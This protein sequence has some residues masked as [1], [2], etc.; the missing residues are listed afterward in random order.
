MHIY[1]ALIGA[2][3]TLAYVFSRFGLVRQG[4][5]DATDTVESMAGAWRRWKVRAKPART[6][7]EAETDPR[8]AAAAIMVSIAESAGPLSATGEAALAREF[9]NVLGASDGSELVIYGRW[10]TRDL[11][12]PNAVS[13]QVAG[14]L[15]RQLWHAQKE[16]LLD[17]AARISHGDAVQMRAIDHLKGKLGL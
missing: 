8:A 14:L 16:D 10:L 2:L 7:L 6:P 1:A 17:M 15:K 12:D 3:G 4:A 11:A 9:R 13:D 5:Y